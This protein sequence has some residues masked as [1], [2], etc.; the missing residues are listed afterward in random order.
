MDN[1]TIMSRIYLG[2]MR[3]NLLNPVSMTTGHRIIGTAADAVTVEKVRELVKTGKL[4]QSK[5]V[6]R[7]SRL[8]LKSG[9]ITK[10][11]LHYGK[12][13]LLWLENVATTVDPSAKRMLL[14]RFYK[15]FN[16]ATRDTYHSLVQTLREV[17]GE[18]FQALRE[19]PVAI[20]MLN[21]A[22]WL[23]EEGK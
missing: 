9:T 17:Y 14:R 6:V 5:L 3:R 4:D 21:V 18:K 11:C 13:K 12:K 10:P 22:I 15:A 2:P 19:I 20:E 8:K 16:D 1:T 7:N 23:K